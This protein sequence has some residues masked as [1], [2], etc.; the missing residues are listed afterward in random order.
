MRREWGE[1]ALIE[2]R[3]DEL[4]LH[5]DHKKKVSIVAE[6]KRAREREKGWVDGEEARVKKKLHIRIASDLRSAR[7]A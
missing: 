4:S 3:L 7:P 6:C 2:Y 5:F 1:V